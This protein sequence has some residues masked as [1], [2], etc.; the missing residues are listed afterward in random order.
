MTLKR[1]IPEGEERWLDPEKVAA[2][3]LRRDSDQ[4]SQDIMDREDTGL[5]DAT[6]LENVANELGAE[7]DELLYGTE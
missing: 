6:E 2:Y 1:E 7:F 3:C 5:L 4:S